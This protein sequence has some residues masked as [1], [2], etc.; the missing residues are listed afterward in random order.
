MRKPE[1]TPIRRWEVQT[2]DAS[3]GT[4]NCWTDEDGKPQTFA[5]EAEAEAELADFIATCQESVRLGHMS[6]APDREDFIVC[7]VKS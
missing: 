4:E 7:E 3:G 1:D 6:D 2:I 5:T